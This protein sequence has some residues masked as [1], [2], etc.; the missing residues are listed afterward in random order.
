MQYYKPW[1]LQPEQEDEIQRQIDDAQTIVAEELEAY[2]RRREQAQEND[3]R[4]SLPGV[5][6]SEPQDEADK[7]DTEEVTSTQEPEPAHEIAAEA[8]A[9]GAVSPDDTASAQTQA[10]DSSATAIGES[11]LADEEMRDDEQGEHVLEAE[12]DTVIY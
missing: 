11:V 5:A 10:D 3:R 4:P 2:E 8:G 9:P 12:E 7:M 6:R 1:E